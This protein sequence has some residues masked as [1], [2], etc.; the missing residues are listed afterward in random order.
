MGLFLAKMR[1]A[2]VFSSL[3]AQKS[4]FTGFFWE[5]RAFFPTK[6]LLLFVKAC[7]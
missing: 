4:P 7:F 1:A 5:K 3:F 2:E 6:S